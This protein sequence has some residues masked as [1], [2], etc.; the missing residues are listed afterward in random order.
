[1]EET[2]W[3]R[4]AGHG[5]G[6]EG[7]EV[8]RPLFGSVRL[9]E[10]AGRPV[11]VFLADESADRSDAPD[12]QCAS[13]RC[14]GWAGGICLYDDLFPIYGRCPGVLR[15][16]FVSNGNFFL[17]LRSQRFSV[18]IRS[19]AGPFSY[20]GRNFVKKGRLSPNRRRAGSLFWTGVSYADIPGSLP[21]TRSPKYLCKSVP[22]CDRMNTLELLQAAERGSAGMNERRES[23][24]N[25]I[26]KRDC[27]GV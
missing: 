20:A 27:A 10:S 14:G 18:S 1:M 2:Q 24:G 26:G 11:S 15:S 7:A 6:A 4:I 19:K 22:L 12:F 21:E 5:A 9:R 16:D 8:V 25:A 17:S 23:D 3:K 13:Q